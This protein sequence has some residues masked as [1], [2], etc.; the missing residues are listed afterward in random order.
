MG[1]VTVNGPNGRHVDSVEEMAGQF[2]SELIGHI[3]RWRQRLIDRPDELMTLEAE[4][5]QAFAHGADLLVAGLIAVV[6]KRADFLEASEQTRVNFSAPLAT[7]RQRKIRVRLFG[8]LMIW[9]AS[10]YCAPRKK[11]GSL[12][13]SSRSG[14]YI[15]LAQFGCG[16]GVT[17][18]LESRIARQVAIGPSLEFARRELD[19]AG[20]SLNG[21]LI[22]RVAYQCGAGLLELRTYQLQ[23]WRDGKLPVGN[24]LSCKRVTVQIDGGRTKIRGAMQPAEY[25]K[26]RVNDDGMPVEDLPGR[27]KRLPSRTFATEWREPKLVTIFVH[28]EQGRMVK[29]SLPTIDGTFL[30][31]DAIAELVAMHLVRLGAAT[32][33]SIT[34]VADGAPWIWDRIERIVAL[35]KLDQVPIHQVLDNCHAAHHVSLALAALGLDQEQRTPLYRQYRTL[36]RNGQWRRVIEELSELVKLSDDSSAGSAAFQTEIA[37]LQKHGDAGHLSYPHFRGLGIPLGSGAIESS[38]RRVINLRLKS[39]S[40]Y[41]REPNAELMLH[42]RAQVISNRWD[43]RMQA[44]RQLQRSHASDD[45]QWTPQNMSIKAE[46]NNSQAI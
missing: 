36:L 9:I 38:I 7:G 40:M 21:K 18:A 30:G 22:R 16:K 29:G 44:K 12:S 28:D 45:W 46:P 20:L 33:Q 42:L 25:T 5:H 10:L 19:R 27:S 1:D 24:E 32:A 34:F 26:E 37:Y 2:S 6:M 23:Q 11:E 35:A 13:R 41:W 43:E 4:V 31:P 8:G 14:L 39:N 17:P 15:E 3:P